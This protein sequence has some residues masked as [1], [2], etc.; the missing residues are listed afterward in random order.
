VLKKS[1]YVT[2]LLVVLL[3]IM[4]V[5]YAL[6]SETLII[7][8]NAETGELDWEIKGPFNC[9]DEQGQNDMNADCSWD[10]WE[11]DKDVGGPTSLTPL[12]SDGDGDYDT[13]NVTLVNT[14]PGYAEEIGFYIHNCGTIPLKVWKVV[15]DGHV[16][17]ETN[18]TKTVFLDL[19]NDGKNDVKVRWGDHLGDQLEPCESGEISLSI[20]VLQ[21]APQN[22]TLHFTITFTAVQWNEYQVPT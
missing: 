3:A 12:D 21:E 15:I 19:N 7:S 2:L 6:W 14:Y 13:L 18:A 17:Y 8:G 4:G 5:S 1:A 16:L 20:L 10:F 11:V 9:M 22:Q